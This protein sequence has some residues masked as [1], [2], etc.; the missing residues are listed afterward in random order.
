MSKIRCGLSTL[1]LRWNCRRVSWQR[2]FLLEPRIM[3]KIRMLQTIVTS[4]QFSLRDHSSSIQ[5]T[6]SPTYPFPKRRMDIPRPLKRQRWTKRRLRSR[7]SSS[8]LRRPS[9]RLIAT[10]SANFCSQ[11]R[12]KI[13]DGH[14]WAVVWYDDV[15]RMRVTHSIHCGLTTGEC[16]ECK[17]FT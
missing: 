8:I 10:P 12:C 5:I 3:K 11:K 1:P 14:T 13:S 2:R 16:V 15:E 17:F 9:P 6:S 7:L 4:R